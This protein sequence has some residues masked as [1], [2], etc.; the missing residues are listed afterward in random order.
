MPMN[1]VFDLGGVVVAWRPEE[2]LANGFVDEMMRELVARE[3]VGHPDW[4]ALDR[5]DISWTEVIARGAHRTG[6]PETT[7]RAFLDSIP[8]FLVANPATVTLLHRLKAN[9]HSLYCLSNMPKET[10]EYL[11]RVHTFWPVFSGVVI[12][13]RVRLCK[14]ERAIYSHLLGAYGLAPRD[15]V[16]V[17]DMEPN[18]AAARELGIR[19]IRFENPEQCERELKQLGCL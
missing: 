10:I 4:I 17:D 7:I 15:T 12:S 9:G 2:I 11:E 8:A 18:V 14:P 19:T 6:L 16:F 5:G 13:S 1:V 3:V